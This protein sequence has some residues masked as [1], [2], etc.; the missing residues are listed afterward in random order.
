MTPGCWDNTLS[1]FVPGTERAIAVAPTEIIVPCARLRAETAMSSFRAAES[2]MVRRDPDDTFCD[3]AR[4]A[5]AGCA[6]AA[7]VPRG[8]VPVVAAR[9]M[10]TAAA[11]MTVV[12]RSI[13]AKKTR[14]R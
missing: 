12:E 10:D 11:E 1:G 14:P 9:P 3:E 2:M 7:F 6:E 8:G 13:E 5:T 4:D